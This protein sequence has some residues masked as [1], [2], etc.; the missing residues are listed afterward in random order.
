MNLTGDFDLLDDLAQGAERFSL[1][2]VSR[3]AMACLFEIQLPAAAP[4]AL[5]AARAAL[6]EIDRLETQ[7]TV[8]R[9]TSEVSRL[10]RLAALAPI[11]L[12]ENLFN[13]LA[14]SARLNA[15]LEG[16]F[17]ISAGPLIKCWGFFRGPKRV[18]PAEEIQSTLQRVGMD[19]LVLD[20]NRR[21][22]HFL[23]PEMEINLGSIG[24]GY[25]L[26]RVARLLRGEWNM[27]HG[28]LH[29]GFSSVLALGAPAHD[30]RGWVVGVCDPRDPSYRVA[31]VRLKNQALGTS[32]ATFQHLE[33]QGRKLGHILDPR[34]GWPAQGMLGVS[35]VAPTAAEADPLATAFFILGVEK[36][37]QYCE[38]HPDIGALLTPQSPGGEPTPIIRLGRIDALIYAA[39]QKVR[40]NQ[41]GEYD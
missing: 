24:K 6:D 3:Q 15:E 5:D 23:R 28:L 8:Y 40:Q 10:N 37:R 26:D 36:A 33:Y 13:L 11:P 4:R 22:L 1:L 32:A 7:L 14:L 35:V 30:S 18:P 21:T 19:K 29:G 25:A 38:N 9:D 12:E 41:A 2:S 20:H 34:S 39:P 31:Q 16:A 17:D 27:T